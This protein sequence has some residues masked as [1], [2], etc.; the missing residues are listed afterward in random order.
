MRDELDVGLGVLGDMSGSDGIDSNVDI[1]GS[2]SRRIFCGDK[3]GGGTIIDGRGSGR[4]GS[5]RVYRRV[6]EGRVVWWWSV[7][8]PLNESS[9]ENDENEETEPFDL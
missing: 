3:V 9:D 7:L 6:Q 2:G 5:G 4:I 8:L 1:G